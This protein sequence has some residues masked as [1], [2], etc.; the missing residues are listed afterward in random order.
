MTALSK[1]KYVLATIFFLV[2][3]ILTTAFQAK[4]NSSNSEVMLNFTF[5]VLFV[6]AFMFGGITTGI[7]GVL[8]I[9]LYLLL[10]DKSGW[11]ALLG[12]IVGLVFGI[13]TKLTTYL[14]ENKKLDK[15]ALFI[16]AGVFFISLGIIFTVA[17]A[18]FAGHYYI[19]ASSETFVRIYKSEIVLPYIIGCL[20]LVAAVIT[21]K[22]KENLN[23]MLSI[24]AFVSTTLIVVYGIF[25]I[26]CS[27]KKYTFAGT[28][29]KA[30]STYYANFLISILVGILIAVVLYILG[31]RVIEVRLKIKNMLKDAE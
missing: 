20:F 5:A 1:L 7:S 10:K 19:E 18:K 12:L 27:I 4:I 17:Y 3:C 8:G 2:A 23:Q 25:S 16:S 26:L 9:C 6:C 22:L 15:R 11:L 24:T 29:A 28:L 21:N 31:V 13:I 14:I 30:Y